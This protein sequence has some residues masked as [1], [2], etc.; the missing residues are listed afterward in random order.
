MVQAVIERLGSVDI[1]S[2]CG[3]SPASDHYLPKPYCPAGGVDAFR[4]CEDCVRIRRSSGEPFLPLAETFND[5][6]VEL[7]RCN[8][9]QRHRTPSPNEPF[10]FSRSVLS[11]TILPVL[12]GKSLRKWTMKTASG[13]KSRCRAY[14]YNLTPGGDGFGKT[15]SPEA[16]KKMSA[17]AKRR[18]ALP[19]FFRDKHGAANPMYGKTHTPENRKKFSE[20]A[21]KQMTE[22]NPFLAKTHTAEARAKISAARKGRKLSPE[23]KVALLCLFPDKTV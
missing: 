16:R 10:R 22:K 1:Y 15:Y 3:D 12:L 8:K 2:I 18:G 20:L 11:A 5:V 14:G 13:W 17:S 9:A 4:L 6:P 19:Q 7:G 23:R 21:K